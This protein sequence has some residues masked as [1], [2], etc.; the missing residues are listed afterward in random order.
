MIGELRKRKATFVREIGM[1]KRT[2]MQK[3]KGLL[4]NV[5]EDCV[6]SG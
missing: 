5:E 4:D 1:H 3:D 2:E 6:G